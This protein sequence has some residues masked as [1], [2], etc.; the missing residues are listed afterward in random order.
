MVSYNLCLF[1]P[2]SIQFLMNIWFSFIALHIAVVHVTDKNSTMDF[3]LQLKI[4]IYQ[5]NEFVIMQA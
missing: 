3:Y 1:L 2:P 5:Y 4:A